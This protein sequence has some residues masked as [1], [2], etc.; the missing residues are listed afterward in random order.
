MTFKQTETSVFEKIFA[1]SKEKIRAMN[2]CQYLA[3]HKD[4][5]HSNIYYTISKWDSQ[6]ALDTYRHSDLFKKTWARTK[7]L[8]SDKPS[9]HSLDMVT[10]L[11]VTL[12]S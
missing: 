3:L 6:D 7:I 8:F 1:E 11:P 4:H 5:H 9:A 12:N 10:E 2:G